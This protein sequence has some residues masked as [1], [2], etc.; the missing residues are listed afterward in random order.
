MKVIIGI[1]CDNSAFEDNMVG[2]VQRIL[3]AAGAIFAE[4]VEGDEAAKHN[5]RDCNGNNVGVIDVDFEG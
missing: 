3:R 1:Q 5:L 2:E 4:L